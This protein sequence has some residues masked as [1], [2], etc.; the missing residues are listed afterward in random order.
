MSKVALSGNASGT[1]TFTIASPNSNTDRTLT[2]PDNTGTILTTATA[3]VP[4][5][6]P[7]FAATYTT[8]QVV[9]V[10]T[11]V[12]GAFSSEVFDTNGNYD[13]TTNYRFTPTVAGYYQISGTVSAQTTV[14][15]SGVLAL[16]YKNGAQSPFG[17]GAGSL[18]GTY[19]YP[20]SSI[21]CLLYMNGSTDYVE[22]YISTYGASGTLTCVA[23]SFSAALVRSAT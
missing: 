7:A 9:S 16:V 23:N 20:Y 3:G 2:L 1:G 11:N 12:K 10:N 14:A 18:G 15:T 4:V 17:Y 8:T 13:P 5:N 6:G 19:N 22:L 21:S